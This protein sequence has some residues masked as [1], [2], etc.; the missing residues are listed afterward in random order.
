MN[1]KLS[2]LITVLA[3]S[4]IA[5]GC[6][7]SAETDS[8]NTIDNGDLAIATTEAAL[9]GAQGPKV[10]IVQLKDAV[11]V[12]A[13]MTELNS[14]HGAGVTHRYHNALRGGALL[15]PNDA[16]KKALETDSRVLSVE[17]D[18]PVYAFAKPGPITP[19]AQSSPTGYRLIGADV[20]T[21]EGAGVTVAV[22]D[23]GV[24]FDHTD[25]AANVD[26]TYA[27]DCVNES[28]ETFNDLNGHGTHVSGTI[29]AVNNS[30]GSIG[31]GQQIKIA[32]VKVLNRRGSGSWSSIICGIDHVTANAGTIKVANMSLGGSGSECNS[33][34][35]TKSALQLAIERSVNAGVTY[36]VAAGN[37]GVN[38]AT[39]VPAAYD[40]VITVSAYKDANGTLSSDDGWAS[41]TNFG[42][43][44]D[45][46]APGVSIYSTWKGN[47]YNTI[48]GTSMACPHVAAAAALYLAKYPGASPSQ[49]R[50]G[51]IGLA[52]TSY[53]GSTDSKHAE[54]LLNVSGL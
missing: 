45:I 5:L 31:I 29:A 33:S 36:A 10:Y 15:V 28:G 35:C 38:A 8:I 25:L 40:A 18:Q 2:P 53:P 3:L 30:I 14:K 50:A 11:D 13:T 54:P 39:K 27:K 49:V 23:T 44:V 32:P 26:L 19:P 52:T 1:W 20:T 6:N 17:A 9:N 21:N 37:E 47:A 34:S 48:S 24:D 41:W 42:A 12:D 51:L 22:L 43:D 7:G 46:A 4:A 16:A